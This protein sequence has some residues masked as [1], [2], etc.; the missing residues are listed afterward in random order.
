ML[1]ESPK[2]Q[3]RYVGDL[4]IHGLNCHSNIRVDADRVYIIAEYFGVNALEQAV[5]YLARYFEP[6]DDELWASKRSKR[7]E[8][9]DELERQSRTLPYRRGGPELDYPTQP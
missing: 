3:R 8:W 5:D 4:D 7:G 2:V 6:F 9:S 1:L